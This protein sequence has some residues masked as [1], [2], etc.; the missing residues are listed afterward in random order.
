MVFQK[1][2]KEYETA[3]INE[4]TLPERIETRIPRAQSCQKVTEKVL[5]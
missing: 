1:L 3:G 4:S 2:R 5:S